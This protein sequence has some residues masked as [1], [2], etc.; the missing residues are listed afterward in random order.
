MGKGREFA[1]P[2]KI[3][4]APMQL[5]MCTFTNYIYLLTYDLN[6]QNIKKLFDSDRWAQWIKYSPFDT[7]TK[8]SV[9]GWAQPPD[10]QYRFRSRTCHTPK[11]L[12]RDA[13]LSA[14]YAVVVCLSV[15]H[16]LAYIF[17]VSSFR[18][19]TNRKSYALYQMAMFLMTFD[20]GGPLL[21]NHPNFFAFFVALHIFVVSKHRDFVFGVQVDRI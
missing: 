15:C 16:T 19:S 13:M 14:V 5:T 4:L 11:F 3:L 7:L 17:F 20:F 9:L 1:P 21:P 10:S 6:H 12:L 8:G 2:G 18:H